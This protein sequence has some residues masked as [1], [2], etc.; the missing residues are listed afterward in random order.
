M[1]RSGLSGGRLSAGSGPAAR[2]CPAAAP[3]P[4]PGRGAL[5]TP[6]TFQIR[7]AR[8]TARFRL[9]RAR[10]GRGRPRRPPLWSREVGVGYSG[11]GSRTTKVAPPPVVSFAAMLAPCACAMVRHNAKAWSSPL[12][13]A[14]PRLVW[15]LRRRDSIFGCVITRWRI[16]AAAVSTQAAALR[17]GRSKATM[18]AVRL[19]CCLAAGRCSSTFSSAAMSASMR[20]VGAGRQPSACRC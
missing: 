14:L 17:Q 11:S 5:P 18:G 8:Y 13:P 6:A 7:F 10:R 1:G 19:T 20:R 9:F 12:K 3:A 2:C 4:H 15:S 16:D